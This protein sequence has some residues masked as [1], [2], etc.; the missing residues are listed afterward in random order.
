M[1]HSR[2]R[3]TLRLETKRGLLA[4]ALG[5]QDLDRDEALH[6]RLLLREMDRS[7]GAFSEFPNDTIALG[8]ELARTEHRDEMRRPH[9]GLGR[10]TPEDEET[11]DLRRDLGVGTLGRDSARPLRQTDRG[12]FGLQTLEGHQGLFGGIDETCSASLLSRHRSD[13]SAKSTERP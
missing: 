6:W 3:V 11:L 4:E 5:E 12:E 13:D 2:E 9:P 1:V 7:R 8:D 10:R